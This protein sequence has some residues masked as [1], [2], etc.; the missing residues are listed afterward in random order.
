MSLRRSP[1][2]T[3]AWIKA[4]ILFAALAVPV[5]VYAQNLDHLDQEFSALKEAKRYEEAE[6]LARQSLSSVTAE[7]KLVAM[8]NWANKL[9][10]LLDD[11]ERYEEAESYLKQAV[12]FREQDGGPNDMFVAHSL[13]NLGGVQRRQKKY[14]DAEAAIG[15]AIAVYEHAKGAKHLDLARSLERLGLVYTDQRRYGEAEVKLRRALAIYE[16]ARGSEHPDVAACL[17]NLAFLDWEQGRYAEAEPLYVRALTI[18]EKALGA[19]H[20]DLA[21]SLTNLANMYWRQGRFTE[22]ERL[23][24]RALAIKERCLGPEHSDVALILNNLAF[25]Y[26]DQGRYAE[27]EPLLHRAKANWVKALGPEHPNVA[28]SLNNLAN[29]YKNQ[30][31]Y[32]E[33][34]PLY[35]R[36][37][38]IREKALG[39]E[40]PEVATSLC[41]LALLYWDEGRNAEAEPLCKRSLAIREKVLVP[42][43]PDVAHS[44]N[45][46][47]L[48]YHDQGRFAEALALYK[49]SLAIREKALGPEHPEVALSLNNLANLYRYRGSYAEAEALYK[50]ALAIREKALGPDHPDVASSLH[51]LALLKERQ[52]R[53][54]QAEPFLDRAINIRDRTGVAPDDRFWSYS[55]RAQIAW[56]LGRRSQALADLRHALDL[57]EEQRGRFSGA[58]KERAHSFGSFASAF[59]RMV[60]WQAELGNVDEALNAIERAHARSLLDQMQLG[61][62]D[63]LAGVPADQAS[64]LRRRESQA[65]SKISQLEVR[66]RKIDETT[67]LSAEER[68]R[69]A[70]PIRVELLQARQQYVEAYQDVRNA[71]PAYRLNVTQDRKPV[72]LD[73]VSAWAKEH[74]A[75]V[76]EYFVGDETS[77]VL[78]IMPTGK[79]RLESLKVTS[80]RA[81]KLG[82]EEG[83]L[84]ARRLQTVLSNDKE[85]GVLQRLSALKSDRSPVE[86]LA[87]LWQ[88]LIPATERK[89]IQDGRVKQL[90]VIPDGPLALLP[91]EALVVET[92]AEPKYLLDAR[93]PVRYA[94]SAT[95]LHKLAER[96][97]GNLANERA[98]VLAVGDPAYGT[99]GVGDAAPATTLAALTPGSRY[100]TVGG[101]LGRLPYSGLEAQWV[102]KQFSDAGI[103]ASSFSGAT[104]TERGLRYWCP[105]RRILHLAC[106][107]L[108]DERYGN[109]FGALAL[110]P[111]PS[112]SDDPSDDGFL[113][114]PEIYELDLK[115]YELAILSACQTNYGPQ[116]KGEGTWALS[117]GFLVAGCRRVVASNWLVDDEAAATL[118]SYFCAGLAQAE[119]AGKPID[120]AAA[121]Q[122]AKRLVRQQ[123]KWKSP[124]YWASMVLIGPP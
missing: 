109:F 118:V 67:E 84:S 106:H 74:E 98:P 53:Y 73:E 105:G 92:G 91:F 56:D 65:Q 68:Q 43:H 94:P 104:A 49:R 18:G 26:N 52:H 111:G 63:L 46:L 24:K 103:D 22:A 123:E 7:R 90:I 42:E 27:A 87:A 30:G 39:P 58:E 10:N 75:L 8:G 40:H 70:T 41:G 20:H 9:G 45:S 33:A 115:G 51:C 72:A 97:A 21:Y 102:V 38:A 119:K 114:L 108:A 36:S 15:R 85:T 6:R 50:R 54:D 69:Q 120:H 31:R 28:Q 99:I 124:Y 81:A 29:V 2:C 3:A 12:A 95:V 89:A 122:Q 4:A 86:Q 80:E 82:I 110:T 116:Q 5:A 44:L 25:W 16:A 55:L 48:L 61:A 66:L 37:L 35:K 101:R 77:F 78:V 121:L 23:Y 79:P 14:A 113:T 83:A 112:G 64:E 59:E 117:R 13:Y 32:A 96:A 62:I 93:P 34:E 11:L 19:E 47:A 57:A 17:S 107:G 60:S 76:L 1:R 88:L 100:S 71:S